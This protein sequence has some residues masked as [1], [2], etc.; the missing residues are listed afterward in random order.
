M[1]KQ[2]FIFNF[3]SYS[4]PIINVLKQNLECSSYPLKSLS[5]LRAALESGAALGLRA[6]LGNFLLHE[7]SSFFIKTFSE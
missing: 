5:E 6:T 3:F 7:N 4:S 1:K 2:V